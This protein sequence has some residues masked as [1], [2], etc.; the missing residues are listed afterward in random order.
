MPLTCCTAAYC[1]ICE[2]PLLADCGVFTGPLWSTRIYRI[3]EQWRWPC[4]PGILYQ[5]IAFG[6]ALDVKPVAGHGSV[7]VCDSNPFL[8]H[9]AAE[10]F[11]R[12][13]VRVHRTVCEFPRN[14]KTELA[15]TERFSA[16]A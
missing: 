4:P 16:A 15:V 5:R 13:K 9:L 7:A 8:K 14:L 1:Q 2:G 11:S 12:R 10:R 3:H 6:F